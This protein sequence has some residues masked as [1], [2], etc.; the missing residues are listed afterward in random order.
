MNATSPAEVQ[1]R[2][3][4]SNLNNFV[5][6]SHLREWDRIYLMAR[7]FRNLLSQFPEMQ[8]RW[9]EGQWESAE[10]KLSHTDSWETL[11]EAHERHS[12]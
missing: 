7:M 8:S 2:T 1:V 5:L 4:S 3:P 10:V 9:V 11:R 6:R 12:E